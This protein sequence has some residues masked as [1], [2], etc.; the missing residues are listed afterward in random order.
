MKFTSYI[1][2]GSDV[3][4]KVLKYFKNIVRVCMYHIFYIKDNVR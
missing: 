2:T 1:I 4:E 3:S